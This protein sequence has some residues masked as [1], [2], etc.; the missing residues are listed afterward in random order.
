MRKINVDGKPKKFSKAFTDEFLFEKKA[1]QVAQ[2]GD[3][4]AKMVKN[5]SKLLKNKKETKEV[6]ESKKNELK[7]PKNKK[8][9]KERAKSKA[10]PQRKENL[11]PVSLNKLPGLFANKFVKNTT[12]KEN[13]IHAGNLMIHGDI[14]IKSPKTK[15][16][17]L[18]LLTK[19]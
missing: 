9:I 5:Q 2:I 18:P 4:Y 8:D 7:V 10:L 14:P 3:D 12:Q 16:T 19:R 15:E 13:F 6:K 11:V 17:K 1:M